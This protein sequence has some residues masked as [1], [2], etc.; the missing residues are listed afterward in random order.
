MRGILGGAAVG[1]VMALLL[2]AAGLASMLWFMYHD[3][4]VTPPGAADLPA[5][6]AYAGAFTAGGALVGLMWVLADSR[7]VTWLAFGAA[8]VVVT[9][10][11]FVTDQGWSSMHV[12]DWTAASALGALFG[13]TLGYVA[14]RGR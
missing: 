9:S 14:L 2:L 6:A 7:V 5:F 11:I 8:G 13:L 4:V 10:T 3:V 1:F 12:A